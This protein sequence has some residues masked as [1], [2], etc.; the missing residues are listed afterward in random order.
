V[1]NQNFAELKRERSAMP[2]LES[3]RRAL[4]RKAEREARAA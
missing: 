4:R 1:R 2:D 3:I